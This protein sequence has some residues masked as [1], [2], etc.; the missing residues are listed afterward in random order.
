MTPEEKK[1]LLEEIFPDANIAAKIVEAA[2][3]S[4]RSDY[5]SKSSVYPYYKQSYA[6]RLKGWLDDMIRTKADKVLRCSIS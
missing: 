4:D 2:I 6:E 5:A 1:K 3:P